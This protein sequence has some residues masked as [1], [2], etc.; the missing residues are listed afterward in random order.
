MVFFSLFWTHMPCLHIAFLCHNNIFIT[1]PT[2]MHAVKITQ[3]RN[4]PKRGKSIL[5]IINYNQQIS[6]RWKGAH[7]SSLSSQLAMGIIGLLRKKNNARIIGQFWRLVS[8]D[9]YIT[10]CVQNGSIF[11]RLPDAAAASAVIIFTYITI[12][13]LLFPHMPI[14]GYT[15][16]LSY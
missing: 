14:L 11:N 4:F 7:Y 5:W 9:I 1:F 8:H 13:I 2:C 10:S 3:Q 6:A 15:E 12:I 16:L